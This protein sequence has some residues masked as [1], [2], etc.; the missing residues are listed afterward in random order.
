VK[1]ADAAPKVI[2]VV[3]HAIEPGRSRALELTLRQYDG[4]LSEDELAELHALNAAIV[5]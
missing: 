4:G 5:Q 2:E 3:R 1:P